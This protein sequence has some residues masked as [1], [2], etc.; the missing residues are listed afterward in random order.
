MPEKGHSKKKAKA[1]KKNRS[2][3]QHGEKQML[4]ILNK[5][6]QNEAIFAKIEGMLSRE[7]VLTPELEILLAVSGFLPGRIIF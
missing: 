7:Y 6:K 3:M 2:M 4:E 1:K 5:R